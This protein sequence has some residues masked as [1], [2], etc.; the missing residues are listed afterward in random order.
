MN[1][2]RSSLLLRV[3][4]SNDQESWNEFVALY[5][6]LL[7]RYVRARGLSQSD[8]GDIVQNIFSSL[9]K[10]MEKFELDHSRGRFRTWL[11]R[12]TQ[13]E[14]TRWFHSQKRN[15]AVEE[16]WMEANSP[17]QEPEAEWDSAY[18]QR[19][20]EFS[21]EKIRKETLSRT[22]ACFEKHIIQGLEGSKVAEELKMKT[23]TVYVNSSRILARVR[24]QCAEYLEELEGDELPVNLDTLRGQNRNN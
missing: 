1:E 9:V 6:P 10:T 8:A 19:I 22:W 21:L 24:S 14:I 18:L 12:V 23:G 17:N 3:R 15:R 7:F 5:E 16:K 4:N 2:T 20:L 11:W 13:N